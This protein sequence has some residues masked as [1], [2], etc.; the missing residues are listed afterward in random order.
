M[1]NHLCAY[2]LSAECRY[3]VHSSRPE[4]RL[5]ISLVLE[6]TG[7][8]I[9]CVGARGQWEEGVHASWDERADAAF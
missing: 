8:R 7:F 1:T 3:G 9:R 2:L 6:Y 5:G 4:K